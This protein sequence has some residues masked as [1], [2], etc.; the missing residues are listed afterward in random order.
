MRS[1]NRFL[2]AIITG[3]AALILSGCHHPQ[4][5][6]IQLAPPSPPVVAFENDPTPLAADGVQ[7]SQRDASLLKTGGPG[8][9]YP[10]KSKEAHEQGANVLSVIIGRN[11]HIRSIQIVKAASPDLAA[12]AMQAVQQ[13]TYK[14][15]LIN[16]KPVEVQTQVTVN[17]VL[18]D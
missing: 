9:I 12:S 3:C 16:E 13:W 10:L 8:P 5:V 15:Y 1:T 2:L 14:P 18:G 4:Y 7:L 6:R 17:F 11:G